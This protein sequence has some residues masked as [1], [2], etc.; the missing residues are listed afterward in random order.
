[1]PNAL[2]E[3][4]EG[5]RQEQDGTVDGSHAAECLGVPQFF[6]PRVGVERK[7]ERETCFDYIVSDAGV[8]RVGDL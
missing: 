2:A 8:I 7:K 3:E 6:D 4:V 1:M 5:D